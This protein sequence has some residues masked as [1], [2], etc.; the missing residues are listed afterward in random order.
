MFKKWFAKKEVKT[1]KVTLYNLYTQEVE[2]T[3]M[4][5][6]N[7]TGFAIMGCYDILKI[8]EVKKD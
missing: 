2:E 1:Y 8:E 6:L 4:Q 5:D 3:E 7:L